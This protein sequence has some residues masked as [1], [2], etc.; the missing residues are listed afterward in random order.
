MDIEQLPPKKPNFLLILILFGVTILV[1]L[2]GAYFF[3]HREAGHMIHATPA[4]W[5]Q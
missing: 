5:L 2:V 1:I 3:M 4:T